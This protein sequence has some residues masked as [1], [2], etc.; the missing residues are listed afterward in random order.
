[1]AKKSFKSKIFITI[2]LLP[3]VLMLMLTRTG[4]INHAFADGKIFLESD[5][6]SWS[7]GDELRQD[8]VI[9]WHDAERQ[10][11]LLKVGAKSDGKAGIWVFPIPAKPND[12]DI[13]VNDKFPRLS[14]KSYQAHISECLGGLVGFSPLTYV[15]SP[16]AF[17]LF[18]LR[19][20]LSSFFNDSVLAADFDG[21]TSHKA[22]SKLGL[23]AQV[24]TATDENSLLSYLEKRGLKL[25]ESERE[26]WANYQLAQFSFVVASFAG[27]HDKLDSMSAEDDLALAVRFKT[28][29]LYFP[30]LASKTNSEKAIPVSIQ[31]LTDVEAEIPAELQE[32]ANAQLFFGL[33]EAHKSELTEL[34][35]PAEG[36][37]GSFAFTEVQFRDSPKNFT[38]DLWFVESSPWIKNYRAAVFGLLS[39]KLVFLA[40]L[41]VSLLILVAIIAVFLPASYRSLLGWGR[42]SMYAILALLIGL[43][44]TSLLLARRIFRDTGLNRSFVH[45]RWFLGLTV[46]SA[47]GDFLLLLPIYLFPMESVLKLGFWDD[48]F[49]YLFTRIEGTLGA[50]LMIFSFGLSL[51]L[52][53]VIIVHYLL[54]INFDGQLRARDQD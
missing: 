5:D 1:M 27:Q 25:D 3:V 24:F 26:I 8:A 7:L 40:S 23:T 21:I 2:R 53:L 44:F 30:L 17:R 33:I 41:S 35:F 13:D 36:K 9:S 31:I 20:L 4:V 11:L 42:I 49:F 29:R 15:I 22:I 18:V 46:L 14:G 6:G 47:F 37:S 19:S 50:W 34:G 45:S 48:Y 10:Q 32:K 43:P 16:S 28:E 12:I 38:G 52:F 54:R 39:P 51:V